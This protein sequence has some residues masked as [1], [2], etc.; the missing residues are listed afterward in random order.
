MKDE[1]LAELSSLVR[2][3]LQT[4]AAEGERHLLARFAFLERYF[5]LPAVIDITTLWVAVFAGCVPTD[6]PDRWTPELEARFDRLGTELTEAVVAFVGQQFGPKPYPPWLPLQLTLHILANV[7]AEDEGIEIA[8]DFRMPAPQIEFHTKPGESLEDLDA[9][10][11]EWK[12]GVEKLF[13][14]VRG[15]RDSRSDDNMERYVGWYFENRL[16]ARTHESI[17]AEASGVTGEEIDRKRVGDTIGRVEELLF[18]AVPDIA[19]EP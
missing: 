17:A 9:R 2:A 16:R 5:V 3:K 13:A 15:K 19:T 7:A 4:D 18:L 8:L 12:D 14:V 11:D 10:F 6:V 1:F